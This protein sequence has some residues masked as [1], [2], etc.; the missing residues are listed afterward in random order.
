[1]SNLISA[2]LVLFS[3]SISGCT[4]TALTESEPTEHPMKSPISPEAR[5]RP[6]DSFEDFLNKV[7]AAGTDSAKNVLVDSFMGYAS[8]HGIPF[9]EGPSAHFIFRGNASSISVPGDMNGWSTNTDRMQNLTGT[10]FYYLTGSFDAAA[11]I[12]YKFYRDGIW[13]LDPLNRLISPGDFGNSELRMPYYKP[14]SEIEYNPII[15]HGDVRQFTFA[16]SILKNSRKIQIYLP[17]HYQTTLDSFPTLY[18]NDGQEYIASNKGRMNNVLDNL[19]SQGKMREL[20]VIFVS[21]V[22]QNGQNNRGNEYT[23]STSYQS[24]LT[25]E[26][27]PHID[28]TYRT[29]KSPRQRGIMGASLGGLISTFVSFNCPN[30]FG[31]CAAQSPSYQVNNRAMIAMIQNDLRKEIVFYIDTG[32]I[33]D[34]Q[35]WAR[36]MRDILVTKE[37]QISYGEYP[38][39]HNWG[40][41]RARLSNILIFHFG[42]NVTSVTH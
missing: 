31:R 3:L 7:N 1:M 35:E 11:R 24:F 8:V 33:R 2:T 27:V 42:K 20:I 32:T 39:G 9:V 36:E 19:I 18:A 26:L 6:F 21:P 23:M 29:M 40:N 14:P 34:A 30:V 15:L 25:N 4:K 13:I 10:N 41:W 5:L 22:D 12:E 37:Y 28:S 38:E 16:S 17:P